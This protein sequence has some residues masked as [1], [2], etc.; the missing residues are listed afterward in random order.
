MEVVYGRNAER[1]SAI[2]ESHGLPVASQMG[3]KAAHAAWVIIQHAISK[4]EFQ[5]K[6]LLAMKRARAIGEVPADRVACLEDRICFFEGR[7]QVYGTQCEAPRA[8]KGRVRPKW[9][10]KVGWR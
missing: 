7:K 1:L 9:A 2:I 4:P 5:R 8:R 3:E 10:R 6:C